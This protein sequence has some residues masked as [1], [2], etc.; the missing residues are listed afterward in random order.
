M[1]T[2]TLGQ[3]PLALRILLALPLLGRI[4]REIRDDADNILYLLLALVSLWVI[5]ILTWG[6][7]ALY[8]PMVALAPVCLGMLVLLTRG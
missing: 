8:L 6:L 7:P 1:A 2:Q 4:T 5:S 3:P